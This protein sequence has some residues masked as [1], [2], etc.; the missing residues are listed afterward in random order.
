MTGGRTL[1]RAERRA[2]EASLRASVTE[3][4]PGADD[5]SAWAEEAS[6]PFP[7]GWNFR[8]R[9]GR[10][11]NGAILVI[12]TKSGRNTPHCRERARLC[13]AAPPGAACW[14]A[15]RASPRLA[16]RARSQSARGRCCCLWRADQSDLDSG[17]GVPFRSEPRGVEPVVF[18]AVRY[19]TAVLPG[20]VLR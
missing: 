16:R 13:L 4:L 1:A 18:F 19:F 5:G 11:R 17:E 8:K 2:I 3:L 20:G 15:A 9:W 6:G 7:Q 10:A 12:P 14:A